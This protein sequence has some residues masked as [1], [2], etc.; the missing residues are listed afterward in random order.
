[1]T[2]EEKAML[3]LLWDRQQILDCLS[4]YSR[5]V[6]RLDRELLLSVYHADAIDDHGTFCGT[7]IEFADYVIPMHEATHLS[8]QHCIFNHSCELAGNVAHTETYFMFVCMNRQGPVSAMNGGRYIDRFER[9]E[10]DWR[11]AYRLCVRDWGIVDQRP[12]PGDLTAFT[13]RR[14][15]LPDD[16][17]A[18]MNAGSASTRN[19][20]DRSYERPLLGSSERL[21]AGRSLRATQVALSTTMTA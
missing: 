4:R 15:V 6:D 21:S 13:A 20:A 5:A 14:A 3:R 2:G 16:V 17:R 19:R 11:I 8:H 7:P 10:G 18:F 12:E 1:M 9:R